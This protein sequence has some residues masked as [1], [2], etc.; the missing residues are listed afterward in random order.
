MY[1]RHSGFPYKTKFK[2]TF[3]AWKVMY[4]VFK[5]RQG[6]LLVD[7]LTRG[8]RMNYE[9]YCK[10]LQKLRWAIKNKRR[11]MLSA[12]VVLL[13]DNELITQYFLNAN[14]MLY[15]TISATHRSTVNTSAGVQMG[16]V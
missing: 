9:H 8:E 1:W 16:G 4:M 11:G 12:N 15:L 14:Q 13:H 3:L 5:G 7:F 2:Q 10:K 6:I